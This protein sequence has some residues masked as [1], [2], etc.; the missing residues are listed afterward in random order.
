MT[1]YPLS[2]MATIY[3]GTGDADAPSDVVGQA[4]LEECANIVAGLPADRQ[5]SV[6]IQM[7]DLD[8]RFGPEDVSELLQVLRDETAGL[9]NTE[10]AEIKDAD[11]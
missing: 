6:T 11:A 7:D 1:T 9:S 4:T 10:I 5:K 3:A 8:L 2:E